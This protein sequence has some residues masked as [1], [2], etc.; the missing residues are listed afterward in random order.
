[1]ILANF[2]VKQLRHLNYL[3]S[4]NEGKS[5]YGAKMLVGPGFVKVSKLILCPIVCITSVSTQSQTT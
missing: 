4:F 3:K 5:V 2:D 1:M